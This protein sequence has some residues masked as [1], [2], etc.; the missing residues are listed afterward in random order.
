MLCT[1]T[2]HHVDYGGGSETGIGPQA[3]N[4]SDGSMHF[5]DWPD[6]HRPL[7]APRGDF[8]NT[9]TAAGD[10][11]LTREFSTGTRVV[12]NATGS[13]RDASNNFAC[14]YWSDSFTTGLGG[15]QP[16]PHAGELRAIFARAGWS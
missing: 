5:P 1:P 6:M 9:T 13:G 2:L 10:I 12:M 4:M 11:V 3:C 15:E 7:G 16:C 14:I 8:K